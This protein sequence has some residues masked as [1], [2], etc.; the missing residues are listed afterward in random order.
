[1]RI[2]TY[3]SKPKKISLYSSALGIKYFKFLKY[4][5][6]LLQRKKNYKEFEAFSKINR[7]GTQKKLGN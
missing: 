2:S 4:K 3:I 5:A 1:M 7:I 6:K